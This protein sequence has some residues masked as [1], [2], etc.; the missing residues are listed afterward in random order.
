M[1]NEKRNLNE[2]ETEKV[3]GGG[4]PYDLTGGRRAIKRTCKNCGKE[5][6]ATRGDNEHMSSRHMNYCEACR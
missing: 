4:D 6:Y 2:M 3:S 1:S 5:F